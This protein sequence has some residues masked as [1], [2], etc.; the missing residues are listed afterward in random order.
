M[1]EGLPM[2]GWLIRLKGTGT[3]ISIAIT[4]AVGRVPYLVPVKWEDGWPVPG[5]SG[6]VP[7]KLPLPASR[8]LVGG[9]VA[10][11]EF[12]RNPDDPALP[13]VWQWNH[14]PDSQCWSLQQRPGYLRLTT[15]RVDSGIS[16]GPEHAYTEDIWPGMLGCCVHRR[17][18]HEGWRSGWTGSAAK[19]IWNSRRQT[20]QWQQFCL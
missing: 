8:G 6:V 18:Q 4:A 10:S 2:A 11:D 15:G 9:I 1:T 16:Q 3:L 7:E 5:S 20:R 13:L 19:T 14:N 12:D 17:R